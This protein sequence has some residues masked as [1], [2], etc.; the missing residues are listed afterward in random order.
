MEN[1]RRHQELR[2][3]RRLG[4]PFGLQFSLF[5]LL[6]ILLFAGVGAAALRG[7]GAV[8]LILVQAALWLF[9]VV[10]ILAFVGRGSWR[11]FAIGFLLGAA[12]YGIPPLYVG[13]G[14]LDPYEAKLPLTKVLLPVWHSVTTP[15]YVDPMTGDEFRSDQV[16]LFANG[17]AVDASAV[18]PGGGGFMA[19]EYRTLDGRVVRWSEKPLR[20]EFMLVAHLLFAV[21][22]GYV[23]GKLATAV[24]RRRSVRPREPAASE[25]I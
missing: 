5:E 4:L 20:E 10:A 14:E 9:V 25:T 3:L 19:P 7:G 13:V 24:Y 12:G 16:Q 8:A 18:P 6:A 1:D 11:A 2:A 15:I 17:V 23:F 21:A 22:A